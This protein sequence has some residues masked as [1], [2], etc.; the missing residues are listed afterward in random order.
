[1]TFSSTALRLNLAAQYEVLDAGTGS[2][3]AR[4]AEVTRVR[5]PRGNLLRPDPVAV[6]RLTFALTAPDGSTLLYIDRAEHLKLN[7]VPPQTALVDADGTV[8]GR[9]DYDRYSLVREAP[10]G[11]RGLEA[12]TDERGMRVAPAA[13]VLDPGGRLLLNVVYETPEDGGRPRLPDGQDARV[14]RWVTTEGVQ[15]AERRD[16]VLGFDERLTGAW[17][18]MIVGSF[19]AFALEFHFSWGG[20]SAPESVPEPYPGHAGLHAAYAEYQRRVVAEYRSPVRTRTG[21]TFRSGVISDQLDHFYKVALPLMLVVA[22]VIFLVRHL[23]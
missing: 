20:T 2:V 19:V 14:T 23:T 12:Y 4:L 18:A 17:R 16:G 3:L 22:T 13:C 5:S 10:A 1:M 21:L 8:L 9:V 7:F 15:V 6:P 11:G